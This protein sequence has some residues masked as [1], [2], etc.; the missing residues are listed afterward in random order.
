MVVPPSTTPPAHRVGWT[1]SCC[2]CHRVRVAPGLWRDA[3][4]GP[5][6]SNSHGICPRCLKVLYPEYADQALAA[7]R[8]PGVPVRPGL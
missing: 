5:V 3:P 4:V 6:H 1:V 7:G 2:N 8:E